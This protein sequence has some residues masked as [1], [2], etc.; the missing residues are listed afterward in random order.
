MSA[1]GM[2]EQ[3]VAEFVALAGERALVRGGVVGGPQGFAALAIIA[4]GAVLARVIDARLAAF[5][6]DVQQDTSADAEDALP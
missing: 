5:A 2:R 3:I 4:V 6:A 1:E